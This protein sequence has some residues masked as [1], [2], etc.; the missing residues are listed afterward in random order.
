MKILLCCYQG[1]YCS[2][3]SWMLDL[4]TMEGLDV[5]TE[6]P[7]VFVHTRP[8]MRCVNGLDAQV[9]I[10]HYSRFKD[11]SFAQVCE[12]DRERIS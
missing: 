6:H 3:L 1:L 7:H 4:L 11:T 8:K 9:S 12:S 2:V 10:F 5:A